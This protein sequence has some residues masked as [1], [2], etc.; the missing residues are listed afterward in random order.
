[1]HRQLTADHFSGILSD[2]MKQSGALFLRV[3]IF[4]ALIISVFFLPAW[5]TFFF[6]GL[7]CFFFTSYVEFPFIALGIDLAYGISS[8][9][10]SIVHGLFYTIAALVVFLIISII[11]KQLFI[12]HRI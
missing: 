6:A 2:S 5:V 10:Q 9:S 4:I 7:G 12:Y 1:M 8:G 3:L 11:K